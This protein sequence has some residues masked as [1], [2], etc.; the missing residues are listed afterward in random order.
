MRILIVSQW[1]DPEPFYK[2][3][4]FA[5]RLLELGHQV[6]VLTGFPNYPGGRVYPG[7]QIRP[8][9]KEVAEGVSITRVALYPSHDNSGVKRIANYFSF[10]C[11]SSLLGGFLTAQPDVIYAYHPP[12]TVGLAACCLRLFKRAPLVYDIQ[13]MWPDS[14]A[15]TDMFQSQLGLRAVGT[16]MSAVYERASRLVVLSPGFRRL[17]VERGVPERKVRV[18]YNWSAGERDRSES[19]STPAEANT[20]SN[21]FTVMFAGNMGRAQGLGAVLKAAVILGTSAPS[22]RFLL[23]GS[24]VEKDHLRNEAAALGLNNVEFCEAVSTEKIGAVLK[25]ADAL[26]V[27]LRDDPLFSITVPSKTQ[28]YLMAGRPVIMGV[29]GDAAELIQRAQAGV[30]CEPENPQSI[31]ETVIQLLHMSPAERQR[32][33]DAGREFYWRH[34]SFERGVKEI[35]S[36]LREACDEQSRRATGRGLTFDPGR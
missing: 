24:G 6:E 26:L 13:D 12:G 5:R 23:I 11:S 14:L 33:G 3:L 4:P 18:I 21:S 1:F 30:L 19:S 29:R 32:M 10:A 20:C 35:E 34:L 9:S 17:L 31:A 16:A 25:S 22:V 36:V 7:Y 28:S 15:A 2:G 27:H 8:W